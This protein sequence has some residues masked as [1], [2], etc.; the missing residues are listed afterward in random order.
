MID[1]IANSIQKKTWLCLGTGYTSSQAGLLVWKQGALAVK[2]LSA[3]NRVREHCEG[4][5]K[6]ELGG[7]G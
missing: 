7:K 1:E 2:T 4:G 5:R 6:P 3:G